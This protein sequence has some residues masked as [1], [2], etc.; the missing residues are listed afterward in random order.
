MD[1]CRA[2]LLIRPE[3]AYDR[4]A[5]LNDPTQQV[6]FIDTVESRG[7]G[8]RLPHADRVDTAYW[9]CRLA[10]LATLL[11][12]SQTR[13]RISPN[14]WGAPSLAANLA[15]WSTSVFHSRGIRRNWMRIPSPSH[16]STSDV[17]YY[18]SVGKGTPIDSQWRGVSWVQS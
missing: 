16:R 14:V 13:T 17:S 6:R 15:C 9:T 18:S 5:F 10:D 12:S 2:I 7:S 8:I 11:W 4:N 1:C 3:S